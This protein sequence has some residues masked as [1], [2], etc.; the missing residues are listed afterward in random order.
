MGKRTLSQLKS[1]LGDIAT[2]GRPAT[3]AAK[4]MGWL[5]RGFS[6][7]TMGFRPMT[8]ALQLTGFVNGAQRVGAGR[9]AYAIRQLFSRPD[10]YASNFALVKDKSPMMANRLRTQTQDIT[11]VMNSLRRDNV[12]QSKATVTKYGFWLMQQ[13]QGAVDT[14]TWLAAYA[15]AQE[16]GV[17]EVDARAHADQ[18][19]IDT[20]AGGQL[21]DL[22]GV[23][24]DA[25]GQ[26]FT[27]AFTY[28]AMLFNQ[29]H[30]V[31]GGA[32]ARARS[33]DTAGAWLQG[34]SGFMLAAALPAAMT[35]LMRDLL[36]GEPPQDRKDGVAKRYGIELLSS[37][38]GTMI[39][40][41]E[42]SGAL[43]GFS[44]QGP[45]TTKTLAAY[46]DLIGQ[47]AQGDLDNG[48]L[49]ATTEAVGGTLGLP[50]GEVWALGTGIGYYLD[51]P[52]LDIRPLLFGPPPKR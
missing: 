12:S 34:F 45:A 48:L 32:R 23:Q 16:E 38:M 10:G 42:V 18:A 11:E 31:V 21:K 8:A 39:G 26:A 6:M 41:R 29:L 36:R 20:Q 40:V 46:T 9:M 4:M 17:A 13:V 24:R 37:I 28:G 3:G 51:H 47:I 7:A 22:S 35:M 15:K 27:G 33:G 1:W 49:R 2:N 52:G 25:Y 19:V 50:S 14:A 30:D 5:R 43:Q 44:Y